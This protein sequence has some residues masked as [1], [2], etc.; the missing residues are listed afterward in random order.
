MRCLV[1]FV[2]AAGLL[3]QNRAPAIDSI[4]RE[5]LRA[6]L[7]FL[8]SD[9]MRG[10]LTN[11]PEY[12][13]AAEWVVSRF[14]R[15]GLQPAGENGTYYQEFEL[16]Y[17]RLGPGN[18]LIVSEGPARRIARVK[19][20][21]YPLLQT[22]NGEVKGGAVLA[23]FG[24]RAPEHGWDDYRGLDVKGKIVLVFEGDPQAEDPKSVF[25]GLVTSDYAGAWRK[26]LMAQ[27]QGAAGVLIVQSG[28][29][30]G[31]KRAFNGAAAWP[32]KP[33]RIER[34]DLASR[35]NRI[36]IPAMQ[37]SEA[38]AE[39]ILGQ[40]AGPLRERANSGG[41]A[42][43]L[44]AQASVEMTAS[45]ERTMITDRN[46]LAKIEGSDPARKSE[47]VIISAH[48]DHDGADGDTILNG[49]D[50]NGSGTVA[51]IEIAEAYVT[52]AR[53]GQRPAR[54]V[55]FASW[56]SEERGLL[57]SYAWIHDPLWPLD[58]TAAALNM[59]MIGRSEEVPEGGGP[60]FFGLKP[61][62]AASNANAV[63]IMGYSFHPELAALVRQSNRDIDLTLRMEYDNTRSNLVRRSDQWPFLQS[64]VPAVFFH[65]GLHPDYHRL[66]DRP[67]KIEYA[68]MERIARLVYQTSWNAANMTGRLKAPEKR[69]I[70]PEP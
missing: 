59:D 49:A 16:V 13:L 34:Y 48:H 9:A 22:A 2:A 47:A 43:Q 19:E 23:G 46:L 10:R 33:P 52:A 44:A 17:G 56:G 6:D 57:G 37:V 35:V 55:I 65:T 24:V 39:Q 69:V 64:N 63:H 45:V 20:D 58:K 38:L 28:A 53:Q 29:V 40:P 18:R 26:I 15:L 8:A 5:E 66:G 51:L 67:E 7:F 54:T 70:P 62:T 30:R 32:E 25:D 21:F 11:T 36:R 68:K 12:K 50:D 41:G 27:E 4:R 42:A 14:E 60:R 3:A 61:Q 31:R 1:F